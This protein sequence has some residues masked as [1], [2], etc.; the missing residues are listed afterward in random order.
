[1]KLKSV[2]G[3]VKEITFTPTP[4]ACPTMFLKV[5]EN[6]RGEELIRIVEIMRYLTFPIVMH[7]IPMSDVHYKES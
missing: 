2:F 4:V 3:R 7:G 5:E 1:M 6:P